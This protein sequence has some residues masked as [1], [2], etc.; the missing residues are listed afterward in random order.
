MSRIKDVELCEGSLGKTGSQTSD[1]V[2]DKFQKDKCELMMRERLETRK[3]FWG[4][5]PNQELGK[6]Q[7]WK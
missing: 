3:P 1:M 6:D 5:C 7:D 2:R 4:S